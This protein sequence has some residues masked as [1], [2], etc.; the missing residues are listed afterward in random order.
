MG[1]SL[2][3]EQ[4]VEAL[5]SKYAEKRKIIVTFQADD[6]QRTTPLDIP[7]LFSR[8]EM[9]KAENVP[10]N[11]LRGKVGFK[12]KDDQTVYL[13]EDS[14]NFYSRMLRQGTSYKYS[15]EDDFLDEVEEGLEIEN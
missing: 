4:Q 8:Y 1:R 15:I 14:D 12:Y 3:L 11:Y 10:A 5:C 2:G 13:N 6:G 9:F 7:T